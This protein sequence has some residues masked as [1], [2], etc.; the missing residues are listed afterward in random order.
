MHPSLLLISL[1][2]FASALEPISTDIPGFTTT[3]L[4]NAA[5]QAPPGCNG[6]DT[7]ITVKTFP[8]DDPFD[9]QRCA[10]ACEAETQFNLD[11]LNGRAICRFFNFYMSL[12]NGL[13]DQQVCALYT[14]AWDASYAT[15]EGQ[16]RGDDHYTIT[17][18]YAFTNTTHDSDEPGCSSSSVTPPSTLTTTTSTGAPPAP[19]CAAIGLC[20]MNVAPWSTNS[21]IWG[22]PCGYTPDNPSELIGARCIFRPAA[23]GSASC[24]T[25]LM[26]ACCQ[27][28]IPG[29]CALGTRC[30]RM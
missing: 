22:G 26:A 11:H 16:W 29:Q 15:N 18:S 24:P 28:F 7:Y 9:A 14:Q 5:I 19:T 30:T 25:G 3:A 27:G 13:P 6:K 8:A 1:A 2:S 20:C 23:S 12:K 17:G 21:A 10:Q 4:D